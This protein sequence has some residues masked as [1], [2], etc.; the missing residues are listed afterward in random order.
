MSRRAVFALTTAR[1]L[2]WCAPIYFPNQGDTRCLF[3]CYDSLAEKLADLAQ[4]QVIAKLIKNGGGDQWVHLEHSTM[5]FFFFERKCAR[6]IFV[7][8]NLFFWQNRRYLIILS[9]FYLYWPSV[10]SYVK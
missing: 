7:R 1:T 9:S 10:Y 2:M 3:D 5:M 6:M 4:I 8:A